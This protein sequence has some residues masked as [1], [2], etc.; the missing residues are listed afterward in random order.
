MQPL[1]S[2][3]YFFVGAVITG[4]SGCLLASL[5]FVIVV[6]SVVFGGGREVKRVGWRSGMNWQ[7]EERKVG[8]RLSV[9]LGLGRLLDGHL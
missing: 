7:R 2:A 5:L 9:F 6:F 1:S 8:C 4:H 3:G